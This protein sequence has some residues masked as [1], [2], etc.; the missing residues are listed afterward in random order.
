MDFPISIIA[1]VI[2]IFSIVF[3]L[4]IPEYQERK[5]LI[6]IL[7]KL[8]KIIK[9]DLQH[10]YIKSYLRKYRLEDKNRLIYLI[11]KQIQVLLGH[12]DSM[13][14]FKPFTPIWFYKSYEIEYK[15]INN[16]IDK[17]ID[18]YDIINFRLQK[19]KYRKIGFSFL[20]ILEE[21]NYKLDRIISKTMK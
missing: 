1:A 10:K 20:P 19:Y 16:E 17:L 5:L 7:R 3:L 15:K 11:K 8:D 2:P 4:I 6:D 18:K 9:H 21:M 13:L 14:K 12:N